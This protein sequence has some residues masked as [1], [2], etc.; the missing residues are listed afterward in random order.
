[1]DAK[2]VKAYGV[3]Q[4]ERVGGVELEGMSVIGLDL[5]RLEDVALK[6]DFDGQGGLIVASE[7]GVFG[8]RLRLLRSDGL[9]LFLL[10]LLLLRSLLRG[11]LAGGLCGRLSWSGGFGVALVFCGG[12][13]SMMN[14]PIHDQGKGGR[15]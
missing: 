4:S 15:T 14:E 9:G 13:V 6:G 7:L 11:G 5:L 3:D 1:M 12:E 2:E 10:R 8:G